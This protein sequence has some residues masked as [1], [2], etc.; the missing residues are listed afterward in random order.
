MIDLRSDTVTKPTDEMRAA[1]AAA[2]VGDDVLGEDPTVNRLEELAADITG[3]EAAV[4]VASGTMANLCSLLSH[5]ERGDEVVVG[6]GSHIFVNEVAS[7]AVVGGLQF[8]PVD[9]D[10]GHITPD[11]VEEAI[12]GQNIHWPRTRLVC[13]E[14]THNKAGG[15]VLSVQEMEA[16]AQVARAHGVL[17][18]L[19][20]ARLFNAATY[21]NLPAARLAAPFD[22]VYICL[23]KGL[24]APVGSLTCGSRA[25]I[26]R[27]R[28][29]RKMLGGGMRQAGII[30]AA[31]II[32]LEKMTKRLADDHATARH[33][34]QGIH[35]LPGISLDVS[36][37]QTNIL[38][39]GFTRP[40]LGGPQ[41]SAAL[42]ERG[43][44][45]S[46][47]GPTAMRLVTHHHVTMA[48][49]DAIVAAFRDIFTG[50]VRQ[51][52][53]SAASGTPY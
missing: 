2:E 53:A 32:A 47:G 44:L 22:S 9:D 39:L 37:V 43:I 7:A 40:E 3:K 46:P 25:F 36:R 20:G 18:H 35:D 41:V 8:Q 26:E 14:N 5:T 49:A 33:I 6:H 21:L 15:V 52:A 28:K 48:D 23:S 34:A 19:D 30:A 12:R 4:F 13:L 27:A 1:M 42:R 31:G 24:G 51:P 38:R 16:V 11:Q 17:L 29:Y 50:D 10:S 45:A